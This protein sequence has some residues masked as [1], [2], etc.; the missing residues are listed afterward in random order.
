MRFSKRLPLSSL[1]ALCHS[2]RHYLAAGLTLRDVFRQQAK[3]GSAALQPVAAR[4]SGELEQGEDLEAALRKE[5]QH[6][7]PLFVAMTAVGE[8]S[9][10]LPEVFRE[11]EKYYALQ[12][13]LRRQFITQITWPVLELAAAI[14]VITLLILVMGFIAEM[15]PGREKFDPLG[16]GLLGPSGA[17]IF[18]AIVAAV[19]A[20]LIGGYLGGKYLIRQKGLIDDYLLRAPVIGPCL[21]ALALTRFCLGLRLT[22]QTGMPITQAASLALRA[23]GN[24]AF[25]ARVEE[26]RASLRAG[27]ELAES[28]DRTRLFPRE[29]VKFLSTAEE[30][31]K[32]TEVLE[33]QT[34]YYEEE[35]AR[36]MARLTQ[37]LGWVV[38]LIVAVLIIIAIF[39]IAL[40]YISLL[41]PGR[42]GL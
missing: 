19:F 37:V 14:A 4:I 31:G 20:L 36:R 1:I 2:L 6:F 16:L 11:L 35:S 40:F 13:K 25:V 42:Y 5:E 28:L 27:D 7:P 23:T 22:L 33:H 18:L 21:R 9:G 24:D 26:V 3:K 32:L 38:W 10:M 41:D 29:F 8:E 39:R 34:E 12:Q 30:A 15:N 17:I